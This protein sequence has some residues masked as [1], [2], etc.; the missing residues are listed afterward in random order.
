MQ[1]RTGSEEEAK[2]EEDQVALTRSGYGAM[3][4]SALA[5][6]QEDAEGQEQEPFAKM[7]DAMTGLMKLTY[8]KAELTNPSRLPREFATRWPDGDVSDTAR[9]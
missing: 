2:R 4:R 9:I 7:E 8:G 6:I 3:M 1:A 5:H